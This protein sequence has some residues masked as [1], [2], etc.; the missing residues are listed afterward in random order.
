M[1]QVAQN[2]GSLG[3][4]EYNIIPLTPLKLTNK[5]ILTKIGQFLGPNFPF[6]YLDLPNCG[7]KYYPAK[8]G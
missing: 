3:C 8:H 5:Y 4:V 7:V 6:P 2:S 1:A